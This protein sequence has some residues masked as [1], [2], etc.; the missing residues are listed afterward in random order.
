MIYGWPVKKHYKVTSH[1][2]KRDTGIKGASTNHRGTDFRAY[3]GDP[4]IAI[5]DGTVTEVGY[6]R[7][8][9]YY[10]IIKHSATISSLSQHLKKSGRPKKGAKVKRGK[11]IGYSGGT[12]T[13]SAPH[14]HF[15]IHKNGTPIDPYAFL[16]DR[17]GWPV[18][19]TVRKVKLAETTGLYP[20]AALAK[21]ERIKLIKAGT[22]LKVKSK[23]KNNAGRTRYIVSGG[24]IS[25]KKGKKA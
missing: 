24:Y 15:E 18:A 8:R 22:V 21:K 4:I 7:A 23:V 10:V 20:R 19:T 1:F 14:L 13:V 16:A 6:N 2:G 5:A 3:L 11:R 12:G 25:A 17:A 9:G